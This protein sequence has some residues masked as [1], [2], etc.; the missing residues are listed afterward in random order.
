[1]K[2]KTKNAFAI[3]IYTCTY[4]DKDID[5]DVDGPYILKKIV[6]GIFTNT[7]TRTHIYKRTIRVLLPAA[8]LPGGLTLHHIYQRRKKRKNSRR[9]RSYNIMMNDCAEKR[10]EEERKS[11]KKI[12]NQYKQMNHSSNFPLSFNDGAVFSIPFSR[13]DDGRGRLGPL[14]LD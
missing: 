11:T 12:T 8:V 9:K 1:M 13:I 3:F 7:H 5:K 10:R 14:L 2:K 4:I 6:R